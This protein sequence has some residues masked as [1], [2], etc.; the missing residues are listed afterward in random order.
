LFDVLI[1]N[2]LMRNKAHFISSAG[3]IFQPP[4]KVR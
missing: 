3:E 2:R 1:V 4:V